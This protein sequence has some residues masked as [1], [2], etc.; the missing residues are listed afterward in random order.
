MRNRARWRPSV[1]MAASNDS[2]HSRVSSGS[3]SGNWLGTPSVMMLKRSSV[4]PPVS[5]LTAPTPKPGVGGG[6]G[7]RYRLLTTDGSSRALRLKPLIG[8]A[9]CDD[10]PRKRGRGSRWDGRSVQY[11]RDIGSEAGHGRAG[12]GLG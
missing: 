9:G 3:M 8:R 6:G 7:R 2:S 11:R 4:T 1:S 10:D 12:A 5:P